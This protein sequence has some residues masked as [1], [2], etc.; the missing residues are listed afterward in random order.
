MQKSQQKQNLKSFSILQLSI[1]LR[2]IIIIVVLTFII[3]D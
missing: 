3:E 1:A 2:Y